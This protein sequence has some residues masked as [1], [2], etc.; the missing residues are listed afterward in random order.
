MR[1]ATFDNLAPD[2][3][4]RI[5]SAITY[6]FAEK[7]YAK[8]SINHLVETLGIA[9]GSFFQYFKDKKG[10]FLAVFANGVETVKDWLRDVR[11]T[12]EG[13]DLFSRL[14]SILLSG[15]RFIEAHPDV[16]R[17]YIHLVMEPEVPYK[18]ELLHELRLM[19]SD[20]IIELVNDAKKRGEIRKDLPTAETVFLIEATMDRFLQA[21]SLPHLD[22]GL[23]GQTEVPVELR[24]KRVCWLLK[25][26]LA[27]E[28]K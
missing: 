16:Y 7:G 27:G 12:S 25:H 8:A 26:G 15:V 18:E 20:F 10:M 13:N 5:L 19:A 24:V 23:F 2:K 4:Q 14:E 6:E 11:D 22:T 28:R 17:L 21:R 9:K 3:Q 1:T